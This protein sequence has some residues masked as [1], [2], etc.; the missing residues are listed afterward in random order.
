LTPELPAIPAPPR[1]SIIIV[2]R[3][4][5]DLLRQSLEALAAVLAAGHQIIVVDNASSDGTASLAG[6]FPAAR[7]IPLPKNFGLTKALNVGMRGAEGQFLLFLH[8]DVRLSAESVSLLADT[9]D[10]N[11]ALGAVCP[12]FP[13]TPQASALPSPS[14]P[15]PEWHT[16]DGPADRDVECASGAAIMMRHQFIRAMRQIDERY[17]NYGSDLDLCAQVVRRAGKKIRIVCNVS[18]LHDVLGK[19]SSLTE[20]DRIIGTSVFLGKY[21]GF[22]AGLKFRVVETLKSIFG[23]RLVMAKHLLS[24]QKLDGTQ[25]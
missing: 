5:R 21:Y 1:V 12:F 22:A 13:G 14:H 6:E 25:P 23:F 24:N 7:F 16:V 10:S 20:A 19:D 4:R 3:N 9:L 8:D 15:Y 17:G 11:P 18:G 2:S